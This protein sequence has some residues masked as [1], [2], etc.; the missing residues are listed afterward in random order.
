M[1]IP[2][3]FGWVI[4]L[5]WKAFK[6]GDDLKFLGYV[7]TNPEP[8]CLELQFRAIF[9]LCKL[10][11]LLNNTRKAGGLVCLQN[12]LVNGVLSIA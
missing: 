9:Y 4:I 3:R 7:G 12:L 10:F 8:L 11:N 2:S 6:Y 5:F 1:D